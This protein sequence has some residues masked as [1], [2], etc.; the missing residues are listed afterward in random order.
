VNHLQKR[1]WEAVI[2]LR[3]LGEDSSFGGEFG[4]GYERVLRVSGEISTIH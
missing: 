2:C 4:T 1:G 3:D